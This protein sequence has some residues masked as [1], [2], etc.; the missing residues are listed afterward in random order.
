MNKS[1]NVFSLFAFKN[2]DRKEM[3]GNNN[4]NNKA[5]LTSNTSD[6]IFRCWY[7]IFELKILKILIYFGPF[8]L[9]FQEIEGFF[10]FL[11][12]KEEEKGRKVEQDSC[13]LLLA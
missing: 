3:L 2:I 13:S 10:L 5:K 9:L 12:E 7:Q 8:L 11:F 6:S 1:R 4:N